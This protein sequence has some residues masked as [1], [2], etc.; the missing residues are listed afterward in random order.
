[1]ITKSINYHTITNW[2]LEEKQVKHFFVYD[3]LV[4]GPKSPKLPVYP[5]P[6]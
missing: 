6:A 1:M 2:K 4:N 5:V 3:I